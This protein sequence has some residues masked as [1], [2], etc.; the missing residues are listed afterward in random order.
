[1]RVDMHSHRRAGYTLVETL[2]V[3][4][5]IGVLVGILLPAIQ[6]VRDLAARTKC[7]NNLH[8]LAIAAQQYHDNFGS[9]PAGMRYRNGKDQFQ[10]MSWLTQLLPYLERQDL[11]SSAEDAY[12]KSA[13]P[14]EPSPHP[15]MSTVVP[16][17][18]CPSD[19]RALDVQFA[20]RN[21][22]PVAL[23]CYLGVEGKD[24]YSLDGVLFV[25][26]AV[27]MAEITDGTSCTLLAG[28]RPPSADFQFGWWYAGAGQEF[29]GSADMVLGVEEQDVVP[30]SLVPCLPGVYKYGP[31]DVTNQCDVFHF[32]SLHNGGSNF[33][34]A[35]GSVRFLN[36]SAAPLLPALASRAGGEAAELP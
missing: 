4:A 26:S 6:K 20:Q 14:V 33:A 17:F 36:Y 34:F 22:I 18:A 12:Q 32:W 2:V 8:Q 5:I 24:L 16:A 19:P 11:W 15:G 3:I 27:R 28:E 25:D 35:D 1:M 23:T 9:F 7:A 21:K 13:N 31:G 29:T 10:F 30:Y